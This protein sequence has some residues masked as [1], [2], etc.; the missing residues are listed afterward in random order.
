MSR[1]HTEMMDSQTVDFVRN[2]TSGC[3]A[4]R[5]IEPQALLEMKTKAKL[6]TSDNIEK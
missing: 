5:G 6:A 3:E 4:E 2:C 1:E